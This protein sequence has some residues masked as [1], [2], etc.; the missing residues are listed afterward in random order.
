MFLLGSLLVQLPASVAAEAPSAGDSARAAA[1]APEVLKQAEA[2]IRGVHR[3]ELAKAKLPADRLALAQ[4]L[5]D[6]ACA[7][8]NNPTACCAT[9]TLVREIAAELGNAGLMAQSID[10]LAERFDVDGPA[11]KKQSL[12]A[13]ATSPHTAPAARSLVEACLD[14]MD[15]AVGE[16]Q[17][18]VAMQYARA[19]YAA[20]GKAQDDAMVKDV[21]QRG[22]AVLALQQDAAAAQAAR[23]VLAQKPDDPD[24]NLICGRY[25]C[26]VKSDWSAGLPL[27]A[28]GS[29]AAWKQLAQ[30]DLASPGDAAAQVKLAEQWAKRAEGQTGPAR[31]ALVEHAA[32]WYR[33]ALAGLPGPEKPKII[34]RLLDLKGYARAKA[35]WNS[36]AGHKVD[37]EAAVPAGKPFDAPAGQWVDLL[38]VVD[39][40]KDALTGKWQVNSG[41]LEVLAGD[42]TARLAIPLLPQ[43]DYA[44]QIKFTRASHGVLGIVLPIGSRR[45]LA[46]FGYQGK[47]NGLDTIDGCRADSNPSTFQGQLNNGRSYVLDVGVRIDGNEAA[48]TITLDD[49]PWV[50]YRGPIPSL[51]LHEEWKLRKLGGLGLLAQADLTVVVAAGVVV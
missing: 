30:Q 22:R 9:L 13:A 40:T 19:A 26:L 20:A 34:Q 11:L 31:N 46:V 3:K 35:G 28:R 42:D 21:V 38:P 2:K 1:P 25:A 18:D 41:K 49:R 43:G 6:Q 15:A 16:E 48:V 24:A 23:T 4:R 5:L 44:L 17:Y 33:K 8:K 45:C 36:G 12:I 7:L 39:P 47:A 29:D 10:A 14:A 27:L 32:S 50:F 51:A 37:A